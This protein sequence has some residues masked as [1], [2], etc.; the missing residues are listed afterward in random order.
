MATPINVKKEYS[1]AGNK[2]AIQ[3]NRWSMNS[4]SVQID[5]TGVID[6]TVQGTL[7]YIN[8]ADSIVTW[9][10][11]VSLTNVTVDTFDKIV[12]TPLEAVRVVVNS[13]AGSAVFH[14]M[15]SGEG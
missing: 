3:L 13:G 7:D 11:I 4:Y 9:S 12:D 6:L 15:Q 14:I 2:D 10:D 1:G 5:V 8:R